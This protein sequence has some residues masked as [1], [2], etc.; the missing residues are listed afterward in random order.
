MLTDLIYRAVVEVSAVVLLVGHW[1]A[2]G[3]TGES[4]ALVDIGPA[5]TRLFA[6]LPES[7]QVWGC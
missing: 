3:H 5:C 2:T 6:P 7:S 1:I 4:R